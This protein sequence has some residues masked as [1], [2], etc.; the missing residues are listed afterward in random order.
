M[1]PS[2]SNPQPNDGELL[3]STLST[4]AL[5][6]GLHELR[7]GP[8]CVCFQCCDF[9]QQ[10]NTNNP[11]LFG[12]TLFFNMFK[13]VVNVWKVC[14]CWPLLQLGFSCFDKLSLNV[15]FTILKIRQHLFL[16]YMFGSWTIF[17]ILAL[18]QGIDVINRDVRVTPQTLFLIG[19]SGGTLRKPF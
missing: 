1:G 17:S 5:G 14:C 16:S 4:V 19:I 6:G 7:L 9:F 3:H 2:T 8:K 11:A 13:N 10:N 18:H 12:Q 15:V